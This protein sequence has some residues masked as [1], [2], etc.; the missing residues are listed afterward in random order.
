M[1]VTWKVTGTPGQP[2]NRWLYLVCGNSGTYES[3]KWHAIGSRVESSTTDEDWQEESTADII[4]DTHTSMKTPI[5]SQSFD[6]VHVEPGDD[7]QEKL[8]NHFIVDR[9]AQALAS[10]DILRIHAYLTDGNG[11][12][13]A[14]RYP[15]SMVKPTGIGGDGGGDLTMPVDVTFGGT[16]EK[17]YVPIPQNAHETFEFT[18]GDPGED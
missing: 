5:T 13:F 2:A 12:A 16:R 9:D 17:G 8:L 15:S 18:A 11:H 3:P 7:Y 14:E 1:A 4:G 10:Q 6:S